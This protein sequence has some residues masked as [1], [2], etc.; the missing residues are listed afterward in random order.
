MGFSFFG[1]QDFSDVWK[2]YVIYRIIRNFCKKVTE[3]WDELTV[4]VDPE[5]L[6]PY[7][8]S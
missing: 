4:D 7:N 8:I 5:T 2:K 3:I 6:I 1:F